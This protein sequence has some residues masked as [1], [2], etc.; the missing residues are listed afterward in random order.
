MFGT[1][2]EVSLSA[3]SCLLI[4]ILLNT[5]RSV[6]HNKTIVA[7]DKCDYCSRLSVRWL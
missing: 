5:D 2:P 7:I 4:S 3:A 6:N 1:S